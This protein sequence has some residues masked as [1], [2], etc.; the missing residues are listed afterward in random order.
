MDTEASSKLISVETEKNSDLQEKTAETVQA[1]ETPPKHITVS[2]LIDPTSQSEV[3]VEEATSTKNTDTF[4]E[5]SL[6]NQVR[7]IFTFYL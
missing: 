1:K 2:L 7:I 6:S 4:V 5:V 3:A